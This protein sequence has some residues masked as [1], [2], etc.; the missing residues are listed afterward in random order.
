MTTAYFAFLGFLVVERLFELF[1]S[2]ANARAA[3]ARGGREV[4]HAHF[5]VMAAVHTLF[6]AAC[7]L[8]VLLLERPFVPALGYGALALA[9]GAQGLR[10]WAIA[11]LGQRWNVRIL[12]VP[13]EAPVTRGP[14]RW[15]RHP[16]YAAVIIE[17]AA[18]PLIHSAWLTALVFTAANA[19]LLSVR[20]AAEEK[21][22]GEAYQAAFAGRARFI[23]RGQP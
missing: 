21:A 5:R 11:T 17:L 3:L 1:L 16:N 22:L 18:V 20:I 8:E 2:R 23:P 13:G 10:Y 15:V 12:F 7:A 14:Y 9:L 19:W 4:G 6:L